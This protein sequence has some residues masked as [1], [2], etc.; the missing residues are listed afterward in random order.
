MFD[1]SQAKQAVQKIQAED[2]PGVLIVDDEGG[3]RHVLSELLSRQYE[4]Y[5]AS[6]GEEALNLL[7]SED[8]HN[9]DAVIIDHRMPGMTGIQL[10]KELKIR[11]NPIPRIML[12]AYSELHDV[13]SL[14]NDAGIFR[15]LPKP[16]E[17]SVVK[18]AVMEAVRTRKL[19]R[20]N[21][22]LI[23]IVSTL[24]A[25]CDDFRRKIGL[26]KDEENLNKKPKHQGS[27][28]KKTV[29]VMWG[30]LRGFTK[31]SNEAEP[32]V[33]MSGL[34]TVIEHIHEVVY[35]F[36]G[37][38]DKHNGDGFSAVFGLGADDIEGSTTNAL[39]CAEALVNQ[40]G[41]IRQEAFGEIGE[42]LYLGIGLARGEI[43]VG[44][45]G[46]E[47][48]KDI[49]IF[50]ETMGLAESLQDL[51]KAALMLDEGRSHLG[52]FSEAMAICPAELCE[53]VESFRQVSL[54][55]SIA[56]R[57]FPKIRNIGVLTKSK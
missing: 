23:G 10:C 35:E 47:F 13:I 52:E 50:G 30:D 57:N 7:E 17:E 51:T 37:I 44:E 19:E 48:R 53:G 9:I 56:I 45:L 5:Q 18:D 6:G 36:Q 41:P 15:Y 2:R 49:V 4:V 43:L 11:G 54:P 16:L 31:F 12:T 25:E 29:T 24:T 3:N 22:N 1:W 39:R 8:A 26:N 46:S 32:A 33:V 21:L 42:A 14:V 38:I 34:Q 55:D 40:Y 27:P 20:E 28:L